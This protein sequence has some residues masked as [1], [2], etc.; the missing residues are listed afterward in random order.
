MIPNYSDCKAIHRAV[1]GRA[2]RVPPP[3][4]SSLRVRPT[5]PNRFAQEAVQTAPPCGLRREAPDY[6]TNATGTFPG[7]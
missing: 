7:F 3:V 4:P 1:N 6:F 5:A 2:E